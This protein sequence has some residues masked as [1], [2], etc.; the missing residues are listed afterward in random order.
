MTAK[1][2]RE[3]QKLISSGEANIIVG[4]HSCLNYEY[5]NLGLVV[6]DE[7][8]IFGTKQKESFVREA[9]RGHT[10]YIYECHTD[11][12]DNC[13]R[14]VRRITRNYPDKIYAKRAHPDTDR[15]MQQQEAYIRFNGKQIA[16]GHQCYVVCPAMMK[17]KKCCR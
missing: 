10:F 2:K 9:N 4:T 8:H 5:K 7:E 6:I 11:P 12:A 13:W 14:G 16:L 15:Y 3:A 1:E 17:M